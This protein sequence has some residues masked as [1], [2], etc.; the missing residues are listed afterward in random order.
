MILIVA[1]GSIG[2]PGKMLDRITNYYGFNKSDMVI[3]ADGGAN[4]ALKMGLLPDVVIGDMDSI[5]ITDK[6]KIRE[7]S[8]R[9]RF[10]STS[11]EKDETDTQL[12]LDYALGM[13]E[14]RII[15]TGALGDRIDH[16]LANIMLLAW[17]RIE[18][19]DV[20]IITDKNEIFV[21]RKPAAVIGEPDKLLTLMSLSPYTYFKKTT[22]LKYSLQEEKL[23]FS[24][25]RGLSNIFIDKKAFLDIREGI[26]LV[27]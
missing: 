9:T 6:E 25:V 20:R 14:S 16:S 23:Y 22:G 3:S 18:D 15:I 24:P 11:P 8:A 12:A 27:I 2:D 5:R 26:L 19:K 10:I 17:P 7:N 21:I 1:N 13:G 4:N